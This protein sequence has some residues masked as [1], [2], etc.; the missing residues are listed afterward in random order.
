MNDKKLENNPVEGII[1]A[2]DMVELKRD[3]QNAKVVDW[4]Q[5]NQQQLIA[6]AVVFVIALAGVTLWKEQK[7]A[8]KN[9]AALMYM[10]AVATKDST[11]QNAL[12]SSVIQDF[13]GTG[14]AT[15]AKLKQGASSDQAVKVAALEALIANKGAPEFI[16]QARLDLAELYIAQDET[17]KAKALLDVRTGK[18]YEQLRYYLL[19]RIAADKQE[20]ADYI[21]KSLNAESL[22]NDLVAALE[23]ELAL[24]NAQK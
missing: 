19:S 12:L 20:K 4:L 13:S 5:R 9:A 11:E 8:E 23:A 17:E 22:D 10:K 3:M 18:A 2:A 16:W 24:L 21:Q 1:S 15:L 14:Y 6:G 7:L